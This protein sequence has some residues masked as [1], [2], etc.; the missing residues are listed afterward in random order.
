MIAKRGRIA[1]IAIGSF[2]RQPWCEITDVGL[3]F[4][5]LT[6]GNET[7]PWIVLARGDHGREELRRVDHRP[8][9]DAENE[10]HFRVARR[11]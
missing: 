6:A 3:L 5:P 4:D 1:C 7:I 9:A 11:A 2:K 10:V 8:A